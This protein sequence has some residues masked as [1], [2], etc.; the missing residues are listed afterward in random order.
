MSLYSNSFSAILSKLDFEAVSLLP[1]LDKD[2]FKLGLSSV[3]VD[4]VIILPDKESAFA[5]DITLLEDLFS[6]TTST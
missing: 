5:A 3:I 2:L 6:V 1:L 4:V